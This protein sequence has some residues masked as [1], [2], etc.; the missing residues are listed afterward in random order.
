MNNRELYRRT[1]SQVQSSSE[2]RWEDYPMRQR[3]G[4]SRRLIVAL[5]AA[6][7][8]TLLC[9][10]ALAVN[11]L[12]LRD[13]LLP[14]SRESAGQSMSLSGYL[15]TPESQALGEWLRFLDGC[16]RDEFRSTGDR[17]DDSLARYSCYQVYAP[18]MARELERIAAKYGLK[19]HS[20]LYDLEAHPELLGSLGD[21]MGSTSG[22]PAYLYEDGTFHVDNG[23]AELEGFGALDF[24]LQRSVRGTF[25]DAILTVRD[26]AE[27]REWDYETS[28]GTPVKLALGRDRALALVDLEDCFVT[29]IVPCGAD[30]GFSRAYLEELADR[31]HFAALSPVEAPEIPRSDVSQDPEG[32][33][34]SE[35]THDR[36]TRRL[37][38]ATLRNLLYGGIR[39]DGTTA[40]FPAGASSQFA[41]CDVDGDGREEL[42]LLLS[43]G[44]MADMAGYILDDADGTI[45][46][47]LEAFPDFAFYSNGAVK[48]LWSHNQGLGEMW[49]YDLYEYHPDTDSYEQVG[50]VDSWNKRNREE[51]FPDDV[52]TGG[53]GVVYYVNTDR[54]SGGRPIDQEAYLAWLEPYLGGAAEQSIPYQPLTEENIAALEP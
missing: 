40:D 14:A 21:F 15:E 23:W 45:R 12:G 22:A 44:T 7:V 2:I 42:V 6:A 24:Q 10:T 25:H 38:A 20:T 47:R 34:D 29:V 26:P 53:A 28:A 9:G 30:Q 48:A 54:Y 17:L 16:G 27:Y 36:D 51:D 5:V 39:P 11:F 8:V 3:R 31:F 37:Y 1:F 19:L 46:V 43:S 52:D 49:P 18:E 50:T 4:I 35:G 41:V 13:L 32:P 33:W